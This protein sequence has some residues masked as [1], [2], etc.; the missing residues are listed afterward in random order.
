MKE[1][2]RNL[3]LRRK[4]RHR[5][6]AHWLAGWLPVVLLCGT[7][8]AE[9]QAWQENADITAAAEAYLLKRT[10][11]SDS[12]TSV[13]AGALDP[14]HRLPL[15]DQPLEASMRRG[16]KIGPRTIVGVSCKG[17]RPWAV[18]V[19]VNV[20]V[21]SSVIV[22]AR[23]LPRGH[24]LTA[25]DLGSDERDVSRMVSG[26]APVKSE[27]VGQ[28]LKHQVIAGRVITPTMIEADRV[29]SR[30]QT[31]TLVATG[32]GIN[33]S[34]TGTALMDGALNQRIRVE[35]VNSGRIIE[36]I[37][38]SREHVEIL[39]PKSSGFFHA[40]PKVSPDIADTQ[41]SNNDR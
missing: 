15:C 32:T 17:S 2:V 6:D 1:F 11:G 21:S 24:L 36:G 16:A 29:V 18:Y 8:V 4:R 39:L 38:R 31:V 35:N 3:T 33:V 23:T 12:R 10:G 13:K 27:L 40:K 41:A 28:R 37:V 9:P 19:P 20:F 5:F 22:A 14:R 26:Y 25:A 30:G 34:M 7:S